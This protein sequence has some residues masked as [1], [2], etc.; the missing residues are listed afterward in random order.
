[1]ERTEVF[2]LTTE[3]EVREF[4]RLLLEGK[5][6][7][8][9]SLRYTVALTVRRDVRVRKPHDEQAEKRGPIESS[10]RDLLFR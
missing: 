5:D 10:F 6:V 3:D 4:C 8:P 7:A 2:E 9:V 1:M